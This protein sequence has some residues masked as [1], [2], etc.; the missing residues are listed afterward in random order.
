MGVS[1]LLPD[2]LP[3]QPVSVANVSRLASAAVVRMKSLLFTHGSTGL[4]QTD[5]F[6]LR[7]ACFKT[8]P[9]WVAELD[10]EVKREIC[11]GF[12]A[13]LRRP[14]DGRHLR[15]LLRVA[16]LLRDGHL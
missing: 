13:W 4:I 2:C 1:P 15:E 14:E 16:C 6:G 9:R 8:V 10:C 12:R 11:V 5:V 7:A 3:W